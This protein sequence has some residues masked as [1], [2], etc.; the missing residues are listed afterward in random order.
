VNFACFQAADP[1]KVGIRWAGKK[2]V[3]KISREIGGLET[4]KIR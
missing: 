1:K 3:T 4:R 2:H